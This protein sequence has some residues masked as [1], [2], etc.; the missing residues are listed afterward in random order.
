MTTN[1]KKA[2][3]DE[4]AKF[5]DIQTGGITVH[6]TAVVDTD[7]YE[8]GDVI[9]FTLST[10]EEVSA[11]AMRQENDGMLFVFV[12][13]LKDE[14]PMNETSTNEGGYEASF[15]RKKLNG[16]ILATFPETIKSR[17]KSF[18]NGDKLRI[19]T[20]R[21]VFGQ[22]EYGKEDD[23]SQLEPMKQRKNRIAFQ[24]KGTDEWEWYWVQNEV[25][26]TASSFADVGDAGF[27]YSSDASY[28]NGVR[29]A[30]K[31]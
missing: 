25:P 29:P 26:N 13:C 9:D 7:T 3:L 20:E 8:V 6:R 28:A 16:D 10:G 23:G 21:E 2:L 4:F 14:Y 30:F 18:A 17:M 1:E 19:L 15:L 11:M 24:G 5:L 12:D 27:A 22:N 31:I